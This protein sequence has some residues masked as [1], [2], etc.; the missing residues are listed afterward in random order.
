MA[1]PIFCRAAMYDTSKA[2]GKS[3]TVE[4]HGSAPAWRGIAP[5]LSQLAAV[6]LGVVIMLASLLLG[7]QYATSAV[8]ARERL[9]GSEL[10]A[11]V[12]R[13]LSRVVTRRHLDL[14]ALPGRGCSDAWRSL[15][16]LQTYV[17]Y[18]RVVTLVDHGRVYCS[19]ALGPI[20]LPLS[21]YLE[22]GPGPVT[23]NL[24]AETRFQPGVPVIAVFDALGKDT[25]ILYIVEG[26]YIA[27][28][29]AHGVRYGAQHPALSM[30]GVGRLTDEGRFV[31]ASQPLPRDTERV[32]SGAWPF[33]IELS[34]A[35]DFV[36]ATRWKYGLLFGAIGV[37]L[38]ALIAAVYLLGFAPRRL[39]LNAVRRGL[40]HGE[41]H[42][43]YQPIV[44]I[45]SRN[46]VG[47][48][49]LLR[50]SHPKWGPISPVVFMAEVE[51]S[52]LLADVTRFILRTAAA[53]MSRHAPSL[54]LRIAVNIAP[55]DLEREDFVA[56]VLAVNDALPP[57]LSLTL[58]LTERFLLNKNPHTEA[59]FET[60]KAHGIR[61]AIDDFGTQHSN[62]DLLSRFPF[63]LVKIDRQFVREVDTGGAELIRG[64]V[65]VARHF[66]LQIVAEGVETESQHEALREAGVPF[67]QGYLYERPLAAQQL[68]D[69]LETAQ[70]AHS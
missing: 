33:S 19:S 8:N 13:I 12:D 20:D 31:P 38:N 10:A 54:P 16:E 4:P 26:E 23:I 11:S 3:F 30:A 2:V 24:L 40:K 7:Q 53:E 51:S 61:F 43:V 52:P 14:A 47:V 64:I 60:L 36:S 34:A 39:M 37:L 46:V 22:P 49:A 69:R 35:P 28:T 42:V 29:L 45:A 1:I 59:I 9:V 55:S 48:E 65:S 6:S 68:A 18:V 58:E 25:G 63:D 70:S 62:L 32:A 66:G 21:N 67:G 27:D 15:S 5:R 57:G 50:W 17:A 44:E 56:E 41:L